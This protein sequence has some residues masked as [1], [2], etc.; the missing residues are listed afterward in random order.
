MP[1][2][3]GSTPTV[4]KRGSTPS[5]LMPSSSAFARVITSAAAAPSESGELLPAVTLPPCAN[6]GC[7]FA[8]PSSVVSGRGSSSTVKSL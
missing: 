2:I 8:R 1:M 7:S 5:G 6:A 4:T 3:A